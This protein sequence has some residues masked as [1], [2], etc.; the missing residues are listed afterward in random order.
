[1]VCWRPTRRKR[2]QIANSTPNFAEKKLGANSGVASYNPR[3]EV[4]A[5]LPAN[6]PYAGIF[7]PLGHPAK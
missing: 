2:T 4:K 1:V 6:R 7:T 5:E 3:T